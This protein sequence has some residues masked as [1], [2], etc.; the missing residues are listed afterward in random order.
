MDFGK[1][2]Q[3]F[4]F[5]VIQ[6]RSYVNVLRRL[7]NVLNLFAAP[8]AALPYDSILRKNVTLLM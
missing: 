2:R 7:E 3:F 5:I 6:Y 1:L 4:V 8:D